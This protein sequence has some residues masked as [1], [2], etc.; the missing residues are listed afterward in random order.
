MGPEYGENAHETLAAAPCLNPPRRC[1]AAFGAQTKDDI[2]CLLAAASLAGSKDS[3]IKQ[4]GGAGA[5]Y[6]LGRLDGR[7][8]DLDIEAAVAAEAEAFARADQGQLLKKCGATLSQRGDHL[9]AVGKAL[10]QRAK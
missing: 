9:I 8:P 10:E 7:T 5:L 1:G 4:A 2:H 6:Y 3:K